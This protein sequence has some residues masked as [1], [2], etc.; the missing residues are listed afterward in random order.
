[1]DFSW[2]VGDG[3]GEGELTY[4]VVVERESKPSAPHTIYVDLSVAI[5]PTSTNTNVDSCQYNGTCDPQVCETPNN[6]GA[7]V[8]VMGGEHPACF[9]LRTLSLSLLSRSLALPLSRTAAPLSRSSAPVIFQRIFF[10]LSF[11]GVCS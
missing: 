8:S 4:E 10:V 3:D 5:D 7:V 11:V 6:Y 1:M 9:W 2:N